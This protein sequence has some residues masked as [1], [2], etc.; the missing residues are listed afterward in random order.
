M[1]ASGIIISASN[2]CIDKLENGAG[3]TLSL[4]GAG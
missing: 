4:A 1:A 2:T 3:G